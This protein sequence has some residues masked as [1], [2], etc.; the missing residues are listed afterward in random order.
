[1]SDDRKT[2]PSYPFID[3]LVVNL[4]C[5]QEFRSFRL[6]IIYNRKVLLWSEYRLN[7]IHPRIRE[8]QIVKIAPD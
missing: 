6:T 4:I 5:G 1:M 3:R 8:Q 7:G 2:Q